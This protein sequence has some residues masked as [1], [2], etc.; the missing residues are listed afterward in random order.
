MAVDMFIKMKGDKSGIIKGEARDKVHADEI[1]VIS[2]N[3]GMTGA[4]ANYSGGK[5]ASVQIQNFTFRK[6]IDKSSPILVAALCSNERIVEALFTCRKMGIK[7][8]APV[9]F[10]VIKFE[11]GTVARI[12]RTVAH[13]DER[14]IEEVTI[15]FQKFTEDYTEQGQEGNKIVGP[16]ATHELTTST[17]G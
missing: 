6:P 17:T 13:D 4:V 3:W 14:A 7:S 9:E 11:K 12:N 5:G 2:W 16:S 1:E 8:G 15:S 10:T